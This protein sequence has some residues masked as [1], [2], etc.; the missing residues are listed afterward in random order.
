M[1]KPR[2][3]DISNE[4]RQPKPT[5]ETARGEPAPVNPSVPLQKRSFIAKLIPSKIRQPTGTANAAVDKSKDVARDPNV[6][7]L[8]DVAKAPTNVNPPQP[9]AGQVDQEQKQG[10]VKTWLGKVKEPRGL[11]IAGGLLLAAI[12]GGTGYVIAVNYSGGAGHSEDL[13]LPPISFE[14]FAKSA[15]S[16]TKGVASP[17]DLATLLPYEFYDWPLQD[18]GRVSSCF[19]GREIL[20][21]NDFHKGLDIAVPQGT[22]V[23][24]SRT[25]IVE[26][27]RVRAGDKGYGTFVL[28]LHADGMR[29]LYAHMQPRLGLQLG[30]KIA[31]GEVFAY[32]GNTGKSTGPH[33]HLEVVSNDALAVNP[34]Q[35]LENRW[36]APLYSSVD[37]PCWYRD[38]S[39]FQR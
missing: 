1:A 26:R 8:A 21:V 3:I 18:V 37:E 27:F 38:L 14:S 29:T 36:E 10:L 34:A 6:E 4:L 13:A 33:L 16:S 31:Q 19:G 23:T 17:F 35:F 12:S 15:S 7:D 39:A 30:Q 28:L 2:R 11:L 22:P 24:A 9:K 32:S 25:G 20:G 5:D